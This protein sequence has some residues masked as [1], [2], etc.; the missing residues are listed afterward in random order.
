MGLWAVVA[1]VAYT[2]GNTTVTHF[3]R[4][5]MR[6]AREASD[7]LG[8]SNRRQI[9][10]LQSYMTPA[11]VGSASFLFYVVLAVGFVWAYRSWGWAGAVPVLVWAYVG[12]IF[13]ERIWPLPSRTDCARIA[14]AE[15]RREGKFRHLDEADRA[16]VRLHVLNALEPPA[17]GEYGRSPGSGQ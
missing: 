4:F 8:G 1:I 7:S 15:V 3:Q 17:A 14:A 13:L 5:T 16:L 11:F 6:M 9:R 10:A 12:T 2:L